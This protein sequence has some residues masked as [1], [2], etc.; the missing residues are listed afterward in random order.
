MMAIA[1]GVSSLLVLPQ[2]EDP[3]L[4]QR[5]ANVTT[6]Y[7]GAEAEK[8]ESLVTEKIEEKLREVAEIKRLRSQSR[9]GV[10]FIAI[11]LRDDIYEPDPIWSKIRGKIED[12][13][14]LLPQG[15][16][17]PEFDDL[18]ISA[19]AWIG[20][21]VAES[22]SGS[23]ISQLRRNARELKDQLLALSGTKNVDLFGDPGEEIV[24]EL[25]PAR[26]VALGLSPA[27][28]ARDIAA[29]DVKSASGLIRDNKSET[30]VQFR[31]EFSTLED[32]KSAALRTTDVGNGL[33]LQEV[34]NV[35]RGT[36]EPVA[37]KMILDGR[38]GVVFGVMLRPEVR[39]DL[40]TKDAEKV[41]ANFTEQLPVGVGLAE[42]M[43]QQDYVHERMA[44]L[45]NNL[46][47]SI[48]AVAL[49]TLFFLG[50]RS[51]LLVTATLPIASLMVLAGMRAL[52]IPIHQMSVTGLILAMGLLIDN[53][54]IA[55][56]EIGIGLSRG[57]SPREAVKDMVAR[58]FGPLVA[59]TVTTALSFAPIAMMEGP[60]GEFVSAIAITVIL[61]ISSSLLLALTVLPATA[62]W[63]LGRMKRDRGEHSV[64]VFDRRL[65]SFS[66]WWGHGFYHTVVHRR[67][68]QFLRL[69]FARPWMG[70][71]IGV[72]LPIAGF[73]LATQLKEQFFPPAD[74]DQFHIEVELSAQSSIAETERV[75]KQ[76][77]TVLREVKRVESIAWFLGE[78][79]PPF[80]YNVIARRKN[81]PNYAQA[82]VTLESNRD[83][84]ELIRSL[85]N[86]L[87][88]DFPEA[89]ILVRQLEQGPPFAAPI[90]LRL[91]GQDLK[92]LEQIG[93]E[94]Q[95][96]LSEQPTVVLA[97]STLSEMRPAASIS[98]DVQQAN[99]AELTEQEIADQL[100]ARLEGLPAGMIIEETEQVPVRVRMAKDRRESLES[101]RNS[102]LI[103]FAS[104][105]SQAG[106]AG[107][108]SSML[109][110]SLPLS[111]VASIR[112]EPQRALIT[113]YNG[114]RMNEVQGYIVAG[115]LPSVALKGFQDSLKES[116][117]KLPPGYRMDFGG[118][119]SERDQA[120]GR[121]MANVSILSIGMVLS[122]V[123]ALSSFRL[124]ALIGAVAVLSV[125]LGLGS[126]WLF[127]YP[128]GFMAIIG[129][130]GLIGVA[131]NDSIVVVAAIVANKKA[132]AGDVN[133]VIRTVQEVTRH[134]LATTATTV[135]GFVPLI[136]AGGGFWP[137]L[138]VAVGAG[139]LGA[140][141]IALTFVPCTMLLFA[142]RKM[143][144][145]PVSA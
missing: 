46:W 9:A 95:R 44:N 26:C 4:T 66:H 61:A 58:L 2:M 64:E 93:G 86:D 22:T 65:N 50:W 96:V 119:S 142:K 21:V 38:V 63:L 98:V 7:P 139:V 14:A 24:I 101:L 53:A 126:L 56:D 49:T 91:Y 131:I 15:A 67:Y 129:T 60:A 41:V 81:A 108:N 40:W 123:L 77:E 89:R 78:S 92:R 122:L 3:L 57:L 31:N 107:S 5:A 127:G 19:Y 117:F 140:T 82:I 30:V 11:E 52:N 75:S 34:A 73:G 35:Q 28:V 74:R 27:Q 133:E 70:I 116:G 13:I 125:G 54:I 72:S 37:T 120:V 8:V 23:N 99:W 16:S 88:R 97:H 105:R 62:A 135:V 25:D 6:I 76:I 45:T 33:T 104:S 143:A 36:P 84:Q 10:S 79:V 20:A 71:A 29:R 18:D 100:F 141:L 103:R 32:I 137:P 144:K 128:F 69:I 68:E 109:S 124:A 87:N 136:L 112:L 94:L 17:R 130:M 90:E 102:E 59:S 80:Y 121:L 138:A 113:R 111:S 118:E 12:S 106:S 42:I 110:E 43:K 83:V 47:I 115:T 132:S 85:Q 145:L 39:I 114:V 134:V 1:S 48:V 55:A 51:S